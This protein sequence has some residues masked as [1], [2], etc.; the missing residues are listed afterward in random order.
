MGIM[1]SGLFF[2]VEL[3]PLVSVKG[4]VNSAEYQDILETFTLPNFV[5]TVWRPSCP[6]IQ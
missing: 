5:V 4:T 2:S 3:D 6:N 1:E